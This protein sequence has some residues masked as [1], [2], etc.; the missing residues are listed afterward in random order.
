MN[1]LVGRKGT[2]ESLDREYNATLRSQIGVGRGFKGGEIS[3]LSSF[4]Q[5]KLPGE[6][7]LYHVCF[8]K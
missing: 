1:Y 2:L 5:Q 8:I 7:F 3:T 6:Y 4:C